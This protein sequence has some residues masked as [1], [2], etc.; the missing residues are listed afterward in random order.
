MMDALSDISEE[1]LDC[2]YPLTKRIDYAAFR[3]AMPSRQTDRLPWAPFLVF[4][5]TLALS[6]LAQHHAA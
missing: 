2:F 1:P 4:G 3:Q 5:A 6:W